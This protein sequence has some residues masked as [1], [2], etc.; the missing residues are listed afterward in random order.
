MAG[1]AGAGVCQAYQVLI[2]DHRGLGRSDKPDMHYTT[3][4]FA[5]D[6]VGLMDALGIKKAHLMGHS[7]G[8]RV[9]QWIALD[10]P[11]KVRSLVLSG[12]G[13]ENI[14]RSLRT[15]RAACRWMQLWR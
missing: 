11:D 5:K 14:A 3:R 12:P 7:M 1:V 2:Y 8:A 6:R 9:C 13:R 4:M 15:I 10:Y